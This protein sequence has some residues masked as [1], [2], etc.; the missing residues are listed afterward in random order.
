MPPTW[1]GD[2]LSRPRVTGDWFGLRNELGKRGIVFDVD[3]LLTPQGVDTGGRDTGADLWSNADYT[4]SVDTGKLGPWPDGFL[5][6]WADSGFGQNV[7]KDSAAIVPVNTAALIPFPNDQ[8]SALM[9]AT[10]TQFLSPKFGVVAG[11]ISPL[12]STTRVQWKL[13]YSAGEQQHTIVE[14][15]IQAAIGWRAVG[16]EHHP[17]QCEILRRQDDDASAVCRQWHRVH[18]HGESYSR[19][20]E[21]WRESTRSGSPVISYWDSPGATRSASRSF[22]IRRTWL[23]LF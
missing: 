23:A 9:N 21:L 17:R 18:D 15:I 19:V 1:G 5:H 20:H 2:L 6:V 22:K 4:L 16:I 13:P 3:L 10:L 7:L 8:T 11:K 12:D 14:Y